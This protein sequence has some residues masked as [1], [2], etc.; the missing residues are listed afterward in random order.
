MIEEEEQTLSQAPRERSRRVEGTYRS[1]VAGMWSD[2]IK[3]PSVSLYEAVNAFDD[4]PSH[5]RRMY[6]LTCTLIL[7]IN[8]YTYTMG[9]YWSG[10]AKEL[11]ENFFQKAIRFP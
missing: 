11:Y 2:P 10:G 1:H 5:L 8:T 9:L 7:T 4:I 3:N 6:Q